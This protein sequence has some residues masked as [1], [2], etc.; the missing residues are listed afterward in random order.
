MPDMDFASGLIGNFFKTAIDERHRRDTNNL[1]AA[2]YLLQSGRIRDVNELLPLF[3]DAGKTLQKQQG[4]A[5]SPGA[6]LSMLAN[7]ILKAQGQGGGGATGN[8]LNA[9]GG[10]PQA[11]PP[12]A[13]GAPPPAAAPM[14]A[15]GAAAGGA[16]GQPAPRPG[17][18]KTDAEMRAEAN[19]QADLAS[20]R[21]INEGRAIFEPKAA[22]TAANTQ[23]NIG[24][25]VEVAKINAGT[26]GTDLHKAY[27]ANIAAFTEKNGAPPSDEEAADIMMKT[28]ADWQAAGRK[29]TD[30][31]AI[32]KD[33]LAAARHDNGD[34]DLTPQQ[35]KVERLKAMKAIAL[36][37]QSESP[38]QKLSR[39]EALAKFK[40]G[41]TAFTPDDLRSLSQTA[42]IG[43]TQTPYLD[44]SGFTGKEKAKAMTTAMAAG[45]V[46]V[47]AKQ[48]EQLEAASAAAANLKGF[49]DQIRSKLPK[50][51]SG[52]PIASLE[53][54]LSQY[55]QTDEDLASAVSWDTSVLPLLRAMQVGGRITNLEF[56]TALNARPKISDTLG[57][58]DKKLAIVNAQLK[59]GTAPILERGAK[60]AAGGGGGAGGGTTPTPSPAAGG[61][62]AKPAATSPAEQAKLSAPERVK[63]PTRRSKARQILLA[64]GKV[65]NDQSID[66]LLQKNNDALLD[67]A[68]KQ[69]TAAHTAQKPA[70]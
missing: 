12:G 68:L 67:G 24:G 19:A 45:I 31:E 8:V 20:Q 13:E 43:D 16:Q 10:S 55:F 47:T 14:P 28:R 64:N 40:E 18:L 4:K 57:T 21:K 6:M 56:Q 54:K 69:I 23:A 53:N 25:R 15:Q 36:S 26:R 65:A 41:L 51:A 61:G 35:S 2:N 48:A 63:D 58:V 3:G 44:T 52:R 32:T 59:N 33:W 37:K 11:A 42:T 46:P 30:S 70:A 38:D 60:A 1:D 5:G 22:A 27:N 49:A 17:V 9:G 62:P 50:D 7:P 34:Q 66:Q 29:V 39:A